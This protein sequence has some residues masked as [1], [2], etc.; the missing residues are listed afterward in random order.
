[1][2]LSQADFMRDNLHRL[3]PLRDALLVPNDVAV[4]NLGAGDVGPPD[5]K[6]GTSAR[7]L[8]WLQAALWTGL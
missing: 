6:A 5:V 8:K 4:A 3:G 2:D 1:M 7:G